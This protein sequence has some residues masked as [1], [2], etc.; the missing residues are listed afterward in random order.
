MLWNNGDTDTSYG[1]FDLRICV[2]QV[3][4]RQYASC[5]IH[6]FVNLLLGRIPRLSLN[7]CLGAPLVAEKHLLWLAHART[8]W[9]ACSKKSKQLFSL[10]NEK[11][12]TRQEES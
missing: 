12:E 7:I 2:Y 1:R 5:D 8:S 4:P 3:N 6:K 10:K 9:P 11:I